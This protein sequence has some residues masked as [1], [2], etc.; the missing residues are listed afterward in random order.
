[1]AYKIN[2]IK[3]IAP[4]TNGNEIINTIIN[5]FK[6]AC[7]IAKINVEK[8]DIDFFNW[9]NKDQTTI[10]ITTNN[11][12]NDQMWYVKNLIHNSYL[13]LKSNKTNTDG[14]VTVT[15]TIPYTVPPVFHI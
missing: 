13:K 3:K 2:T 14:T 15:Y 12:T 9:A 6:K 11:I 7:K 1:M 5:D 10:K 4:M 8:I